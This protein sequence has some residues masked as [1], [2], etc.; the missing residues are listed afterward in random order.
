MPQPERDR[1]VQRWIVDLSAAE[2]MVADHPSTRT[3][4]EGSTPG[5]AELLAW[6]R[7]YNARRFGVDMARFP[8]LQRIRRP[9]WKLPSSIPRARATARRAG[10]P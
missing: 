4:C 5:M 3:L 6:C 2:A 10:E 1:W 8:A 9:A 7:L